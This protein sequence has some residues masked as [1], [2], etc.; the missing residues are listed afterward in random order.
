MDETGP[1]YSADDVRGGEI[2]LRSRRR[3]IIFIGG[4]VAWGALMLLVP[5]LS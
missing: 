1:R 4:L 2:I 3:R 5:M